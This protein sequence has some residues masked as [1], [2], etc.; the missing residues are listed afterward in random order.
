ME[1][2]YMHELTHVEEFEIVTAH[3]P[4]DRKRYEKLCRK[5]PDTWKKTKKAYDFIK[6]KDPD[7]Y[8]EEVIRARLKDFGFNKIRSDE[9]TLGYGGSNF[10]IGGWQVDACGE[11]DGIFILIDCATTEKKYRNI[12]Q[13]AHE[14]RSKC[15]DIAKRIK[16]KYGEK[17]RDVK[18]VIWTNFP[19]KEAEKIEGVYIRDNRYLKYYERLFQILGDSIRYSILRELDVTQIYIPEGQEKDFD[20]PAFCMEYEGKKIYTFFADFEILL[21]ISYVCRLQSLEKL[22]YQRMLDEKKTRKNRFI[23]R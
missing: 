6:K 11:C 17:F 2:K 9:G 15:S 12:T 8:F 3:T 19:V 16:A 21:K 7:K 23:L 4:E 10:R 1:I 18:Y 5:K 20:V 13:K 22:G 14:W